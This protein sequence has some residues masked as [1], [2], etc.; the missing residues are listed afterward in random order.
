MFQTF[1]V[2]MLQQRL[3]KKIGWNLTEPIIVKNFFADEIPA[4]ILEKTLNYFKKNQKIINNADILTIID[5]NKLSTEKRMFILNL[6]DGSVERL[7]VT[8]R[9]KSEGE[10][11]QAKKFSNNPGSEMSSMQLNGSW[12]T[13]GA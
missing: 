9:K 7:L 8:H 2:Q 3:Q 13:K 12:T 11:A 6:K 5:F 1:C 4:A 10:L